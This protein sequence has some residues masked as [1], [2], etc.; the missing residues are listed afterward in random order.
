MPSL[1]SGLWLLASYAEDPHDDWA[2][3]VGTFGLIFTGMGLAG[4]AGLWLGLRYRF[5]NPQAGLVFAILGFV[6][7]LLPCLFGVAMWSPGQP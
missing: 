4:V 5:R 6:I 3:L 7:A 1:G 2:S